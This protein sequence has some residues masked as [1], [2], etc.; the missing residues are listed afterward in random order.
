MDMDGLQNNDDAYALL[1]LLILVM[2]PDI[3]YA[4]NY[5]SRI[6]KALGLS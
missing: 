6:G 5:S 2:L 4:Q 3:N 1:Y